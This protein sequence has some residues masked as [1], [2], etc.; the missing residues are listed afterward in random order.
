MANVLVRIEGPRKD[1]RLVNH[2]DKWSDD[3]DVVTRNVFDRLIIFKDPSTR[4]VP[5]IDHPSSV[6][7][8]TQLLVRTWPPCPPRNQG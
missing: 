4:S 8:C 3:G 7:Q 1:N 2:V 5:L 6:Q